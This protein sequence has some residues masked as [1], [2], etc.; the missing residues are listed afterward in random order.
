MGNA[1]RGKQQPQVVVNFRDRAHGRSRAAI[2]SFLLD[3]NRWAQAIDCVHI[4]T[5]HL[6]EKLPGVRRQRLYITALS[7]G[8]NRV[9]RQRRFARAAQPGD[10]GERVA[11]DLN[12]DVLQIVLP[13]APDRNFPNGHSAADYWTFVMW[14][15]PQKCW[16][17]GM[18]TSTHVSYKLTAARV[19][20]GRLSA[21]GLAQ[22]RTGLKPL[23]TPHHNG[24]VGR[25][26]EVC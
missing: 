9:K 10:H 5:L 20:A 25:R 7:L 24:K 1:N 8:I 6:I 14:T 2:G 18:R 23:M 17:V 13:G 12:A 15:G 4:G 22:P 26:W 21:L 11:R 3:G 16:T 19:N